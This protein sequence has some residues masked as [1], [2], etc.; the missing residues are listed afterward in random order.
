MSSYAA[1]VF[2]P[3][4]KVFEGAIESLVAPGAE[5]F[6]EVLGSH[7][8]LVALLNQGIVK[9]TQG[10]K[11]LYFATG[12]GV[13][14]VNQQHQVSLLVDFAIPAT[15]R[16]DASEKLQKDHSENFLQSR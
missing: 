6:F 3:H 2:S 7:A 4:G 13:L 10:T 12:T 8:P 14:E 5:G 9:I 15:S 1:A 11:Q 16:N